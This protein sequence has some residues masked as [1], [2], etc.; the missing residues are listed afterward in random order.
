MLDTNIIFCAIASRSPHHHTHRTR[1]HVK[2]DRKV[3]RLLCLATEYV[4][5]LQE[6]GLKVNQWIVLTMMVSNAVLGGI[7]DTTAQTI[8]AVRQRAVRKPGGITE[9]DTMAIEIRELDRKNPLQDQNV[10]PDSKFLPPPFDFERLTRFMGYGF[11]MAPVQFKWFQFLSKTF[12][13]TKASGLGAAMKMVAFDQLIFA[14]VGT[15]RVVKTSITCMLISCRN[16][17]IFHGHDSG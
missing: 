17:N 14:P 6:Q 7:A 4:T 5:S 1:Y 8:T 3:Q 12:P 15:W 13:I 16:R 9:D 2:I 10:V 11:M